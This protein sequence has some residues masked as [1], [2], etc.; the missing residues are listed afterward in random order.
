MIYSSLWVLSVNVLG[1]A[2]SDKVLKWQFF[3]LYLGPIEI[4]SCANS[5][6]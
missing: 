1:L 2:V 3:R 4:T 6:K 5:T